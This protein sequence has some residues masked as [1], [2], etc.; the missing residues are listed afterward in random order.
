MSDE[1]LTRGELSKVINNPDEKENYLIPP[2]VLPDEKRRTVKGKDKEPSDSDSDNFQEIE[3]EITMPN[4]H[5]VRLRDAIELIPIFSG[6]D[7]ITF[8]DFAIGCE[9]AKS[10]LPASAEKNFVHLIKT[11]LKDGAA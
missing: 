9:E 1:R 2:E 5:I 3:N 11:R 8:R 4:T 10:I 7:N 6:K